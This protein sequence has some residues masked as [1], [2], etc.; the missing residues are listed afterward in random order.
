MIPASSAATEVTIL[1]VEPGGWTSLNAIPAAASI[2]PVLG[3][4]TVMPPYLPASAATAS[5]SSAGTIEVRTVAPRPG[6]ACTSTCV[7]AS[8]E[9]P[10]RPASLRAGR[11]PR[12]RRPR[13]GRS[14]GNPARR[15]AS[16]DSRESCRSSRRS[17]PRR[18]GSMSPTSC[19]LPAP[20]RSTPR[21]SRAFR[22]GLCAKAAG[23][24]SAQGNSSEV[25]NPIW[26]LPPLPTSGTAR[27]FLQEPEYARVDDESQPRRSCRGSRGTSSG[28]AF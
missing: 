28:A 19:P 6:L 27:S 5:S 18:R 17:G 3:F 2:A 14:A 8:S 9:P 10:S 22:S 11:P 21:A 4:I 23:R 25:L 12:A 7:P 26:V 1:N 16:P 24:A 15:S 20:V 13:P